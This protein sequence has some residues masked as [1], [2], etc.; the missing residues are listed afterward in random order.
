MPDV[1][2]VDFDSLGD[3]QSLANAKKVMIEHVV[4]HPSTLVVVLNAKPA[5]LAIETK[6]FLKVNGFTADVVVCNPLAENTYPLD[7]KTMFA[8]RVQTNDDQ[9]VVLV[10][11]KDQAS[12]DMWESSG[13]RF[14]YS[15]ETEKAV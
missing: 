14:T 1:L 9:R 3:A 6:T 12:R 5:S 15:P 4:R 7:F 11:D 10:I 2:L 13:I 8:A